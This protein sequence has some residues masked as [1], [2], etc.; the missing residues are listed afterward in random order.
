LNLAWSEALF[1]DGRAESLEAQALGPIQAAGE[2]NLPLDQ[3]VQKVSEISGYKELFAKAY[4]GEPVNEKTV[5]KAIATY[6]RTVTS[7]PAPFDQWVSGK[8]SAIS[9][10]AKRGFALFNGKANCAACH[11]GW[12]FTD[13]SFHDI[14]LP[15]EDRGRGAILKEIEITQFAFKTPTLRDADR[16]GPYMHD[17]S[18]KTLEDVIEL[19]NQGGRVKRPSLSNEIK[20]LNL[21][22]EEKHDLVEFLKTL[23]S[24]SQPVTI[25]ALPR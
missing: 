20:P 16:R 7:A 1:W 24:P 15:G 2:M 11:S 5:A 9:E 23:T 18:E 13:D 10:S 12:R 6:E 3:M 19:Y 4:P 25:P 14:G 8:G 17:G 22:A 21:T